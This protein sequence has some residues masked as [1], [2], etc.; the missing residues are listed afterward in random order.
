MV[1]VMAREHVYADPGFLDAT[2]MASKMAVTRAPGARHAALRFVTGLLDP[3]DTREALL[4]RARTV[5]DP[6][7]LAYGQAT[8][9][10]SKGEMEALGALPNVRTMI[11]PRGKLSVHEEFPDAVAAAIRTLLLD[12]A[13]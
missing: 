2:L 10:K 9:R 12:D 3:F 8:P 6:M 4:E 7:L 5:Q 13:S 11:L 1:G